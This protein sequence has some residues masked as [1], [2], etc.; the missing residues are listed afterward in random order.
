M[1]AYVVW[2]NWEELG[3]LMGSREK[4]QKDLTPHR[5]QAFYSKLQ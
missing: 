2:S 5:P 4:D 1:G 3:K